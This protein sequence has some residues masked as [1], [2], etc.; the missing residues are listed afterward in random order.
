[1]PT[2]VG[3][4]GSLRHASFNGGL[5]RAAAE[6]APPG[7]VVDVAS[8][9]DVPLYDGDLET[10]R[11]LPEAVRALKDKIAAADA[12]LLAT[13]EYNNGMPGVLKNAVDWLSRPAS[14][15]ARVFGG[16]PVALMGATPGQGGTSLS[17][18]VWLP[19]IKALG[20]FAWPGPRMLVSGA[21][22]LF[23]AEGN[24]VDEPTR[25]H[26]TKYMAALGAF[27]AR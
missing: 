17:Q 10:A 6:L 1:M 8:I 15:L 16:K 7:L 26:L 3:I 21:G 18:A 13:P 9:R 19:V 14:D 2:I 23:D 27:L 25:A 12:L 11:G 22:K 4:S 24:L 20:A 5:L